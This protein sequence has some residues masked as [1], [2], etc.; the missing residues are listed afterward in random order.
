MYEILFEPVNGIIDMT[1]S[2]RNITPDILWTL[3]GKLFHDNP[4]SQFLSMQSF[5]TTSLM[6]F[7]AQ[8][9]LH[10]LLLVSY[11]G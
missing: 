4:S 10:R 2:L 7:N 8:D 11:P 9:Q 3:L 6:I 1:S 5:T